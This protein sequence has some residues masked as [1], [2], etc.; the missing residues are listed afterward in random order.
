MIAAVCIFTAFKMKSYS[1]IA[2]GLL[3]LVATVM[4]NPVDTE[5]LKDVDGTFRGTVCY[6]IKRPFWLRIVG[7]NFLRK[8]HL[9]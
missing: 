9:R 8:T 4:A 6:L 2:L 3:V 7:P 1:A 5:E